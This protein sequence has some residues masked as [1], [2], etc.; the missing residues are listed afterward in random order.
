MAYNLT[1]S[2]ATYNGTGKFGSSMNGGYGYTPVSPITGFPFT[3]SAWVKAAASGNIEVI[4]GRAAV[5]WFGKTAGNLATAHY[6]AGAAGTTDGKDITLGSSVNIANGAWHH[7]ELVVTANG[8]TFFVDG[9]VASSSVAKPNWSTDNQYFGVRAFFLD[10]GQANASFLY[11]GEVDE[12]AV[13]NTALHSAAFTPPTAAYTGNEAGLVALYHLDGTGADSVGANAPP[14]V[15]TIGTATAG[16]GSVSVAFTPASTGSSA[17]SYTLYLYKDADDTLVGSTPAAGSPATYTGATN[18]VPVYAKVSA[19]NGSGDSTQSAASN[20]V[21]PAAVPVGVN[22]A[23]SN[24][25]VFYSPYN[26]D[27]RGTYKST[28]NPGAYL[29]FGFTG[30]AVA[31]KVDTSALA[32][33]GVPAGSYPI[34][35][36]IID[37]LTVVD[38]QLTASTTSVSRANLASGSHTVEFH[39]LATDINNGE[40]WSTPVNA[41]RVT[42]FSLDAGASSSN[43]TLRS[44]LQL[45]YGDS[46]N[47]GYVSLGTTSAQPVGNSSAVTVATTLAHAFDCE[48]GTVAFSG[49][50]YEKTGN[51]GVPALPTEYNLYSAGRS[52]LVGG[53]LSPAPDYVYIE[54]GANGATTAGDVSNFLASVRAIAPTAKIIQLVP[55]GGFARS[56]ITSGFATANDANAVLVDLGA[57]FQTGINLSP[58][59]PNLYSLDGL[60]RNALS[61]QRVAAAYAN[62]IRAGLDASAT[63][64]PTTNRTFSV[65]LATGT[66][67]GGNAIPAANLTGLKV[68]C[69]N[70]D[71]TM[72]KYITNG[73]SD[74]NGNVS[75]VAPTTGAGSCLMSVIG[76][77][78]HWSN[79]VTVV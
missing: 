65:Q 71:G 55:A 12:V 66:D 49:Q 43:M 25:S 4:T 15:P 6:G 33:A 61:N 63:T 11:T 19:S 31:I 75:V 62:K 39:F 13:F 50:G 72:A 57:T 58:V 46:I 77:T 70:P 79:Y 10:I 60:H 26:W 32:N 45:F 47:E 27:D 53:V 40:R 54:H 14:G 42:G 20:T 16:D 68:L 37:G 74:A 1:T 17:T 5:G 7:L 8:G 44:K 23:Y 59:S 52:R 56:A 51:L 22:L 24:A 73:T 9:V 48:Y 28:N 21:T 18:G 29:K 34:V 38:T 76:A 78:G 2:G 69:C 3:I 36:T 64:T 30:T 67:S 41:V 35:R